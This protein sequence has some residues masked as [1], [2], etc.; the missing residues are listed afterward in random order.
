MSSNRYSPGA[1]EN[2]PEP[3]CFNSSGLESRIRHHVEADLPLLVRDPETAGRLRRRAGD[4]YRRV[5]F[6]E[7]AARLMELARQAVL[8]ADS[9]GRAFPN[10]RIWW[11]RSLSGAK[12]RMKRKWQAEPGGIYLCLATYPE[13]LPENQQLYNIA[14][15]LSI[16]QI[17]RE[18]GV[19]AHIRWLNDILIQRK[20]AAG[21]LAEMILAPRLRERYLLTGIGIN[22]N[23]ERFPSCLEPSSTSLY[24]KTGRKWPIFDL[25]THILSRIALNFSM[26]HDWEASALSED[27]PHETPNPVVR[28]YRKLCRLKDRPVRY[29][30]DLEEGRG[31]RA[32]ALGIMP[33]GTLSL[34]LDSGLKAVLNTGEIR[35][36]DE[37]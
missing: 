29:G 35:Y 22:V 14:A 7:K 25:G 30:K 34:Q 8:Q 15:G 3:F 13:L 27:F 33:D 12:G 1:T 9:M 26:L 37:D 28:A 23:Q 6:L 31:E 5:T 32:T 21:I 2:S 17:L 16:C 20:K 24:R 36:E 18:W 19:D 11:A 4:L 10:G